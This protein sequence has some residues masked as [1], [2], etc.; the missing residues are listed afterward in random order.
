MCLCFIMVFRFFSRFLLFLCVIRVIVVILIIIVIDH[1]HHYIF[2][3][4]IF[5]I[6]LHPVSLCISS[7]RISMNHS[8]VYFNTL[9]K[10]MFGWEFV[11]TYLCETFKRDTEV[12]PQTPLKGAACSW[13]HVL[14]LSD[15]GRH[16]HTHTPSH[17]HTHTRLWWE[18]VGEEWVCLD[19]KER[20][21]VCVCVEKKV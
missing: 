11:C 19:C 2:T 8:S 20:V 21:C 16:T 1:H 7:I 15:E 13:G 14:H 10:V 4:T 3:P 5:I 12:A 18:R 17:T 9:L 6:T